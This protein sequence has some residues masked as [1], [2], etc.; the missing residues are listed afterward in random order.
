MKKKD[1]QSI[2]EDEEI[3][4][5]IA[6]NQRAPIYQN[7]NDR[8]HKAHLSNENRHQYSSRYSGEDMP[9]IWLPATGNTPSPPPVHGEP[10][11]KNPEKGKAVM[12]AAVPRSIFRTPNEERAMALSR[13]GKPTLKAIGPYDLQ[14]TIGSGSTGKVRL[15]T[16]HITGEQV[17]VK[18]IPRQQ[19]DPNLSKNPTHHPTTKPPKGSKEEI[20]SRERRI[21]RE[22]AILNLVDHDGIVGLKDFIVTPTSFYMIFEYVDGVQLL[23]YIISNGKMQ[24][25]EGRNF[26]RQILNC[27]DYCH[28]YSIVHRDLKIENILVTQGKNIKLLDFGLSNFYHLKGE[29]TTFCGSLYFAAPELL[30]GRPYCGPEVDIWSLGI[31]L[32]V[33]ICGKVPFDD[34]SL[35]ALH[36]KIKKA[37]FEIPSG[38][39]AKAAKL[40]TKMICKSPKERYTMKDVMEDS[41][42]ND[43]GKLE[44]PAYLE[45]EIRK[46][47]IDE[48]I[49]NFLINEFEQIQYGEEEIMG[50]LEDGLN[51]HCE[52]DKPIG[53]ARNG[54]HPI[55]SLYLLAS[56]R[57]EKVPLLLR[58]EDGNKDNHHNHRMKTK[59]RTTKSH[60]KKEISPKIINTTRRSNSLSIV[61]KMENY[62]NGAGGTLPKDSQLEGQSKTEQE[63]ALGIKTAYFRGLLSLQGITST[64]SPLEIRK[65][66]LDWNKERGIR[67]DNDKG[68]IIVCRWQANKIFNCDGDGG[69][70]EVVMDH[71][72]K[73][74]N[75]EDES[76]NDGICIFEVHITRISFLPYYG[77]QFRRLV[78]KPNTFKTLTH[79]I[80]ELL[81]K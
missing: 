29:L 66:I 38:I 72:D 28:H 74:V 64:K 1:F 3:K 57:K 46:Q 70:D 77:L 50:S 2:P 14:R 75:G 55:V 5:S 41:W 15:A 16:H 44:S 73:S 12:S 65:I 69:E 7:I 30:E 63:R 81:I 68:N 33:L 4:T 49:V 18:I 40:L 22:A 21:F 51:K 79:G 54:N 35:S 36:E 13:I 10:G 23:D 80:S 31:I 52:D 24:E 39:S 34:R 45:P 76:R 67:I 62:D 42:I 32:Y 61:E 11:R 25:D 58:E 19:P 9:L 53:A 48:N 60:F 17:A 37:S 43:Q 71:I 27:V 20:E 6:I 26:F 56:K 59:L 8:L 78:G 47:R